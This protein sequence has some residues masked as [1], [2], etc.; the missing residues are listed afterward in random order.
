MCWGDNGNGQLGNALPSSMAA[1]ALSWCAGSDTGRG[2]VRRI[3]PSDG[4]SEWP[5]YLFYGRPT[6][7]AEPLDMANVAAV[8]D[9]I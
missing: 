3:V 6:L 7:L 8:F 2:V 9:L 1:A 5:V 4:T